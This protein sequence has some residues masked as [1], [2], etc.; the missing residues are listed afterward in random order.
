M[1]ISRERIPPERPR[2]LC[3][4]EQ[5][6][7]V[8]HDGAVGTL[9]NSILVWLSPDSVLAVDAMLSTERLVRS[10][11]LVGELASQLSTAKHTDRVMS[12]E[13]MEAL[14][15]CL[16]RFGRCVYYTGQH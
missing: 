3:L 2:Q 15:T 11:D 9:S 6:N 1:C 16:C 12:A 13:R 7:G 14:S 8:L 10:G 4:I 5:S